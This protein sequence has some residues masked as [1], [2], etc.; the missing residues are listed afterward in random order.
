M[1]WAAPMMFSAVALLWG[2][3]VELTEASGSMGG[4]GVAGLVSD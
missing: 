2:L 1:E 4:P 3:A